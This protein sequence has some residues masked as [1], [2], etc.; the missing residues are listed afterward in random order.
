MVE[1]TL[2]RAGKYDLVRDVRQVFQN[3]MVKEFTGPIEELTGRKVLT[4]QSQVLFDPHTQF[5]IF[6]LDPKGDGTEEVEATAEA[7]HRN[8]APVGEAEQVVVG[9]AGE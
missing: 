9:Q 7:Q 6:V 4:Y 5:E 2:L 1:E 3:E 8:G